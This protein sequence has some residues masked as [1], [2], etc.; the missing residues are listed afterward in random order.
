MSRVLTPRSQRRAISPVRGIRWRKR[1]PRPRAGARKPPRRSKRTLL[2]AASC[3]GAMNVIITIAASAGGLE[4]LKQ[5]ISALQL[6]CSASIFIVQYVG[7][8]NSRLPSV[9]STLSRLPIVH[10]ED[11]APITSRRVYVAPPDRHMRL[12]PG[13]IRLDAGP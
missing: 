1:F 11:G 2:S 13:R 10:A 4:P 5:I 8:L 12:E 9:L 6:S 3:P 7:A